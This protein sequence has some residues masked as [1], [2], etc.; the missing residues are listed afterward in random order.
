MIDSK[1]KY[2]VSNKGRIISYQSREAKIITPYN[3]QRGYE[4]VD[5]SIDGYRK[6][7]TVHYL[8]AVKFIHNDEP[9]ERDTIDH[10]DENKSNNDVQNLQ[11][12]S[13]AENIRLYQQRRREKLQNEYK[14]SSELE[15]S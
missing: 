1:G 7:Y 3:N 14:D 9:I 10:I 15:N 4:R 6:T 12:V 2:Y 13:R 11:W 8:V 5:I